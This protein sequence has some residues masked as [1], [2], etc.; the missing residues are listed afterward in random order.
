MEASIQVTLFRGFIFWVLSVISVLAA[1]ENQRPEVETL[2]ENVAVAIKTQNYRGRVTFEH[3]GTLEII[4]IAHFIQDDIVYEHVNY[5]N[6]RDRGV[7]H[8]TEL[9]CH[10]VGAQLLGGDVVARAS[11][12]DAR[13]EKSYHQNM[14]GLERVAGRDSWVVQFVPKDQ[15]R[16]SVILAI[17]V[18][19]YLPT[20]ILIV[21][22]GRKVLERMHFVSLES[23]LA[24]SSF[25]D[26]NDELPIPPTRCPLNQP[27]PVAKAAWQPEW[28][29]PG[30]ILARSRFTAEDGHMD[31]YTDGITAFTIFSKTALAGDAERSLLP[32]STRYKHGATVIVTRLAGENNGASHLSVLGEIP[33]E[34]ANQVLASLR[35]T[36]G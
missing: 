13:I 15:H 18:A 3:S 11:G 30:F 1:A 16:H 27:S 25:S 31:T 29:P 33:S 5:L 36:R 23:S 7:Y 2:L 19:S 21:A 20:R 26:I 35:D 32:V 8:A 14:I 34:T 17:D 4:E 9:H 22:N 24:L 28:V 6:G 10:T 12:R